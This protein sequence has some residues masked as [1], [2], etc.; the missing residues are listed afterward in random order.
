MKIAIRQSLTS[1]AARLLVMAGGGILIGQGVAAS[2]I[3]PALA[4]MAGVYLAAY[5]K[6][7]WDSSRS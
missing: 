4:G 7:C 1:N 3:W 5:L 6:G 2:N